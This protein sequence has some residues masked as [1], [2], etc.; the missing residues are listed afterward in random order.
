MT[1]AMPPAEIIARALVDDCAKALDGIADPDA[2]TLDEHRRMFELVDEQISRAADTDRLSTAEVDAIREAALT[3]LH[4]RRIV[5]APPTRTRKADR[6]GIWCRHGLTD[7]ATCA[8]CAVERGE[9]AWTPEGEM[10][11]P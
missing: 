2:L 5:Q 9:Y 1:R 10:I 3:I 6:S 8:D 4:S 7:R 11:R